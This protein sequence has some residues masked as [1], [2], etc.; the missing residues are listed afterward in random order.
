MP[1][2]HKS[3]LYN[4]K[5]DEWNQFFYFGVRMITCLFRCHI[6]KRSDLIIYLIMN[7]YRTIQMLHTQTKVNDFQIKLWI[8]MTLAEEDIFRFQISMNEASIMYVLD[9]F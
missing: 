7:I 3:T 1:T 4:I 8:I 2:D 9:P 6:Y 5:N